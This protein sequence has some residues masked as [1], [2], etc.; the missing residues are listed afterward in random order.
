MKT[1]L[2]HALLPISALSHTVAIAQTD[3]WINEFHYDNAGVDLGEFVEVVGP[4]DFQE[5]SSLRLTL[6]NGGD[7]H[8]YGVAHT[9]D[10]FTVGLTYDGYT[11]YSKR[12]SGLQNGAPD[13]MSL[14]LDGTVLDTLAY[15]GSFLGASG[16][17]TGTF[18]ADIGLV[19]GDAT[20]AGS[21]LGL[22]GGPGRSS[23]TWNV[24]PEATPGDLNPG[25]WLAVPEPGPIG[26]FSL[27]LLFLLR[28]K[29]RERR[30][31]ASVETPS[32]TR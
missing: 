15:E 27:G 13:G 16:P 5:L 12:I 21:A 22:V 31:A 19:Q 17:A 4:S 28:S 7:G 29:G 2:L 32:A 9:L 25:Q 24:L 1:S 3:F 23:W 18:F 14:D 8:P 11:F 20:L 10:T 30:S 6:Y 26:L